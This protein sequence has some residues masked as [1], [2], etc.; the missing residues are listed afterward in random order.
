MPCS[1]RCRLAS[2]RSSAWPTT[3]PASL[4]RPE[5][6]PACSQCRPGAPVHGSNL[7]SFMSM[8]QVWITSG[9]KLVGVVTDRALIEFCLDIEEH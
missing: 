7:F 6:C 4:P 2:M 8:G 3:E 5:R 1:C 9:G